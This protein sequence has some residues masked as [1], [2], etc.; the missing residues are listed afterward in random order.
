MSL[1]RKDNNIEG[2]I[3]YF[4]LQEWW[5]IDL[6]KEEQN[7]ILSLYK[8]LGLGDNSLVKGK[9]LFTSQTVIGFLSGLSSWFKKPEYRQ[10]GYK[11]I[12]K[13]E[14]LISDKI[15]VLDL[16][17]LYQS[18][19]E[20]YYRNRENDEFALSLAI[21]ACKQQISISE[22][23][24]EAFAKEM[25]FVGRPLPMHVGYT[26]LC[27]IMEK[28]K[29]FEEVIRLS[30]IAKEQGWNGDWDKRIEKCKNKMEN[31]TGD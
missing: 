25:G 14:E 19:I 11:I 8:P 13:A 3:G 24:K 5:L 1:F 26:Q 20:L 6:T 10:I 4:G 27:I 17:F 2:L 15:P 23:A 12:K 28:Q 22:K 29:N 21:E 31:I 18:K 7:I 30:R 16:H 9:T